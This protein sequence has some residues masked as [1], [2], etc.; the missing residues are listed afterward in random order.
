MTNTNLLQAMGGI[1]P[2]LIADAA[3]DAEPGKKRNKAWVK[4]A[5]MA[6]CFC[7]V[8]MKAVIDGQ[9]DS[10]GV[11][12]VI[13]YGPFIFVPVLIVS[14]ISLRISFVWKETTRQSLFRKSAILL[15]AV[16]ILNILGVSL[17]SYFGGINIFGNL[18]IILVSSNV[19]AIMSIAANMLF[20]GKTKAWWIKLLLWLIFSVVAIFV[21]CMVHNI[22]LMVFQYTMRF[23]LTICKGGLHQ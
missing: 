11:A 7:I 17:Y 19:G 8:I 10:I 2:K 22:I 14:F 15:V 18:P 4:W 12:V 1:D 9:S 3:P 16:N 20:G 6:A 23:Q 13:N 5:S 21:A